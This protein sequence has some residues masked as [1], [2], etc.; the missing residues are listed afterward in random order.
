[1]GKNHLKRSILASILAPRLKDEE[2]KKIEDA[3]P[4][5]GESLFMDL[6]VTQMCQDTADELNREMLRI[7]EEKK[8]V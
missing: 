7:I 8:N 4:T 3:H 1:M 2:V 6:L 5:G